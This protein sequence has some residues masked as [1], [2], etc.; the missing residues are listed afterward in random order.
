MNM[1]ADSFLFIEMANATIL[2]D[3][4][5]KGDNPLQINSEDTFRH[6]I[7]KLTQ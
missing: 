7:F 4:M 5:N 2:S 6:Q 1:G 3:K